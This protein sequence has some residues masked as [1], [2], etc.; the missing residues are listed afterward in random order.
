MGTLL[1]GQYKF[2]IISRTVIITMINVADKFV[3][4]VKAHILYSD[5]FFPEKPI[6][7]ETM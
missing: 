2:M 3:V 6:I 5:L 1:E 4:K 7:Y